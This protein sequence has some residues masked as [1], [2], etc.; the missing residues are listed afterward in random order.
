MRTVLAVDGGNSKTDVAVADVSGRLLSRV[1]GPGCSPDA[2]GV[3]GCVE[4]LAPL[5]ATARKEA[6]LDPGAAFDAAA[7]LLAGVDRPEQEIVVAGAVDRLGLGPAV[8][9][10]NDTFAVLLAGS[11]HGW[12]VAVVCG[13]G[14]NAVG[15]TPDG[16]VGRYQALGELSGDWGGGY[17]VGLSALGA[18]IRGSD[19]RGPRTL[20]T[21]ELCAH[22]S[23]PEPQAVAASIHEQRMDSQVLVGLAPLVFG[24]ASRGDDVAQA[25]VERVADEVSVMA[26]AMLRRLGL[27][28][29]ETD[30][31]L[32]GGLLQAGHAALDER[33]RRL[34][35]E[36]APRARVCVLDVP[37]VV[38]SVRAGLERLDV[39]Q[40]EVEM[41][42]KRVSA[43]VGAG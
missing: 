27:D 3:D 42:L 21:P 41:A 13:A 20:L 43:A 36:A 32:G 18:A 11:A 1:V 17:A 7:L 19:G 22:F 28:A 16:R 29:G 8:V 9:V 31:V 34:V 2:L 14:L 38:G 10:S 30:V 23:V 25:I 33:V 5:V 6:G 37:P 39:P 15:V 24:C 40:P 12:G 4:V 35:L 26:V